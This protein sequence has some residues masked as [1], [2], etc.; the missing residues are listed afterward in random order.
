MHASSARLE[1]TKIHWSTWVLFAGLCA[2]L[3]AILVVT[4]AGC[5]PGFDAQNASAFKPTKE[6]P[7][8]NIDQICDV[9]PR[10]QDDTCCGP[11]DACPGPHAGDAPPGFCEDAADLDPQ[12]SAR[13]G[14]AGALDQQAVIPLRAD[15][16]APG[17]SWPRPRTMHKIRKAVP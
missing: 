13:R 7:C 4:V 14:D 1:S 8:G 16:G 15:G 3:A 17:T 5:S 2:F 9:M 10:W 11:N 12:Y 6:A